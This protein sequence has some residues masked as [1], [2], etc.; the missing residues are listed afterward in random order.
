MDGGRRG[1]HLRP[2]AQFGFPL[3]LPLASAVVYA[4]G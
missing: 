2:G 1:T 4:A 3:G